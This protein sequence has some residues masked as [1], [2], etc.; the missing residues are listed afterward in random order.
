[1]CLIIHRPTIEGLLPHPSII[2]E[3]GEH[4]NDDGIGVMYVADGR[5][6]VEKAF[7]SA[8]DN[9]RYG[10]GYYSRGNEEVAQRQA[11][12]YQK[13]MHLDSVTFHLRLATQGWLD[14][15][16]CHPFRVLRKGEPLKD[17]SLCP[18]DLCLMHNGI[19]RIP[20]RI[21][22]NSD[23][24]HFAKDYV[25][26]ILLSNPDLIYRKSF[27]DL[28][29]GFST[30]SRLL[31]LD[32]NNNTIIINENTGEWQDGVWYSGKSYTPSLFPAKRYLGYEGYK[33]YGADR[34]DSAK[35]GNTAWDGDANESWTD[36]DDKKETP[37]EPL[38]NETGVAKIGDNSEKEAPKS[39]NNVVRLI[40]KR[41]EATKED[42][43]EADAEGKTKLSALEEEWEKEK[44]ALLS[45]GQ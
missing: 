36:P 20:E 35:K 1:M 8:K 32:S 17:G 22:N 27:Q 31:F 34:L 38:P 24:W 12:F 9:K 37:V 3:A 11:K 16:M 19:F 44:Q 41:T 25:R 40:P 18:I 23:T 33:G 29:S 26:P 21:K 15:F 28:L 43:P 5:V 4:G 39:T 2:Q 30:G 10:T 42:T 6:K 13:F 45:T 7:F 14:K